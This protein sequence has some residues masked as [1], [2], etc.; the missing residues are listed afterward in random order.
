MKYFSKQSICSNT[1][2]QQAHK[3]QCRNTNTQY[4]NGGSDGIGNIY[5]FGSENVFYSVGVLTSTSSA[6]GNEWVSLKSSMSRDCG[7]KLQLCFFKIG[8]FDMLMD[9]WASVGL[10]NQFYS[11]TK[12]LNYIKNYS[13]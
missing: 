9:D 11:F 5:F 6:T 8:D 7:Y 4:C 10:L 13:A 3:Q 12:S 1:I 2:E